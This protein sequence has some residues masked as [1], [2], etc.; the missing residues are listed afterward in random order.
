MARQ[1]KLLPNTPLII[2][3]LE[4][5]WERSEQG[6]KKFNQVINWL[7]EQSHH[8]IVI[9][10]MN[11]H[12]YRLIR[13]IQKLDS[14]FIHTVMCP[15]LSAKKLKAIFERKQR[16]I[17]MKWFINGPDQHSD[18]QQARFFDHLF[19]ISQGHIGIAQTYWLSHIS[20]YS[21]ESITLKKEELLDSEKYLNQ[22]SHD[23]LLMLQ[24]LIIHKKVSQES[25]MKHN[26]ISIVETLDFLRKAGIVDTYQPEQW[27]IVDALYLPLVHFMQKRNYL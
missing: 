4:L 10:N 13:Q 15:I 22:L 2:D 14:V 26:Q 20:H 24:H 5:W 17:H 3:D 25:L 11:S 9:A 7:N 18:L 19:E 21:E 27:Q 12:A 16:S 1:I 23:Q 8:R 6:L